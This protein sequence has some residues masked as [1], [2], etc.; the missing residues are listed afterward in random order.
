MSN[1]FS[2][3]FGYDQAILQAQITRCFRI[4]EIDSDGSEVAVAK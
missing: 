2:G 3:P 4:V 1:A